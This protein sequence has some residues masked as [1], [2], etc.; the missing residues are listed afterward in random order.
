MITLTLRTPLVQL[1]SALAVRGFRTREEYDELVHTTPD[2][3]VRVML[4]EQAKGQIVRCFVSLPEERMLESALEL[5]NAMSLE[6]HP[7][8]AYG[9][10]RGLLTFEFE[11]FHA[12]GVDWRA[13]AVRI[14]SVMQR[15]SSVLGP[16]PA[17]VR[18]RARA[19]QREGVLAFPALPGGFVAA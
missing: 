2:A 7:V 19:K 8:V 5:F 14:D 13:S 4:R 16:R 17:P 9:A 15:L 11:W 18:A 12:P 3:E 10:G 6:G 1:R